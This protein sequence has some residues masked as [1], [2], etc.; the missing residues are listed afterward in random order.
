[1]DDSTPI[2]DAPSKLPPRFRRTR[3]AVSVFF[4]VLALAFAIAWIWSH[5]YVV[6]YQSTWGINRALQ[7]QSRPG[8]ACFNTFAFQT[9][10]D[11]EDWTRTFSVYHKS[12][13]SFAGWK[14]HPPEH[15]IWL[16]YS[17][18]GPAGF[19]AD[20]RY[21]HLVL[22]SAALAAIAWP[23]TRFRFSLR[24][25]LIATT[26]VAVALGLVVYTSR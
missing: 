16:G 15:L 11:D 12:S 17:P 10:E 8:W 13:W 14:K 21:M 23:R 6:N 3:I 4:G 24:T 25:M 19:M 2:V 26:L 5:Q 22:F 9:K 20:V 1:M 18:W 7:L